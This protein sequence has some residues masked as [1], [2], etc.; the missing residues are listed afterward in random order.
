MT[1]EF[2][3]MQ[4]IQAEKAGSIHMSSGKA[5]VAEGLE[6]PAKAAPPFAIS[7]APLRQAQTYSCFDFGLASELPLPGLAPAA[8]EDRRPLVEL[9]VARLPERLAGAGAAQTHLQ[10][11]G[12]DALLLVPGVARF[13]IRGGRQILVDPL[14]AVSERQLHLFLLG[15]ALGILAHQR[16]LVPLHA[17]AVIA[18]GG[19]HAFCGPSGAGKST[20]AAHFQKRGYDLLCDDVCP[21]AID[22]QDRPFAWPG[23][24]RLKLWADAARALGHDPAA[25]EGVAEGVEKFHLPVDR[26]RHPRPHPIPLRRLYVLDRAAAADNGTITRL[27]GQEAMQAVLANTYRGMYLAPMGLAARHFRQCAAML[28]SLAVYRA[29]RA[30]GFDVFA[31]EAARLE[32]HMMEEGE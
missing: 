11:S 8:A 31:R 6:P 3:A 27:T 1:G 30:W 7:T 26:S 13:L 24:P 15:S 12:T 14:P 16:G 28:E 23:I 17:N 10:V 18:D 20:L 5:G 29:P 22:E 19:A 25:L 2:A 32:R 9:R 21:V 4:S